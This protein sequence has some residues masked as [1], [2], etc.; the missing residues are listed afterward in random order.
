MSRIYLASSWRNEWQPEVVRLLRDS[1][2]DVYDFRNPAPGEDGFRWSEIDPEW[3][4]W[5]PERYR[6]LLQSSPI[7][8][9]GY[10]R[11]RDALDWCDCCVILL[12]SGRSAHIEAGYAIGRGKQTVIYLRPEKFE[13]EL[14]YLLANRIVTSDAELLAALAGSAQDIDVAMRRFR[15][16]SFFLEALAGGF[17]VLSAHRRAEEAGF[18]KAEIDQWLADAPGREKSE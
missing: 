15:L 8:A 14:M 10:K 7:A 9:H 6:S 4:A 18:T 16:S 13:P 3:Q 12:P 1:G 17:S 11:D 2:H 5:T